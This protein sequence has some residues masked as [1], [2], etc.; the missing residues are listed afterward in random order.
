MKSELTKEGLNMIGG[1]IWLVGMVI[2][3]NVILRIIRNI[4]HNHLESFKK[5]RLLV[6]LATIILCFFGFS[7]SLLIGAIVNGATINGA[8]VLLVFKF[9]LFVIVIGLL[10]VIGTTSFKR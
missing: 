7:L 2:T 4:K 6:L 8:T 5:H 1:V 3:G 10:A 9:T